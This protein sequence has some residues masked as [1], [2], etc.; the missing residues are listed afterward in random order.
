MSGQAQELTPFIPSLQCNLFLD[1]LA[2]L[3]VCFSKCFVRASAFAAE[4]DLRGFV[5]GGD[6]H[7]PHRRL[8]AKKLKVAIASLGRDGFERARV[9]EVEHAPAIGQRTRDLV[10]Q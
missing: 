9:G 6:R 7:V 1:L 8:V 4:Q 5:A 10:G 2:D 3:L